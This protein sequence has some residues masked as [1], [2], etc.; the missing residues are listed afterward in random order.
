MMK[1][2]TNPSAGKPQIPNKTELTK[3]QTNMVKFLYEKAFRD[4]GSEF[5][6]F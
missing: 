5:V 4:L 6:I 2:E 1:P 3:L